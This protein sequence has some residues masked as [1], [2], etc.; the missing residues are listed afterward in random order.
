[1]PNGSTET[2]AFGGDDFKAY[3]KHS[4]DGLTKGQ[5][6]Q[7]K[8]ITDMHTRQDDIQHLLQGPM[9]APQE[10]LVSQVQDNR[11]EIGYIKTS[12]GRNRNWAM[13]VLGSIM[14]AL[15]VGA[16]LAALK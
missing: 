1:M 2:G 7:G 4:L 13:G 9:G 10:G 6:E 8:R 3:M 15:I 11:E 14:A 16:L 12:R 5:T